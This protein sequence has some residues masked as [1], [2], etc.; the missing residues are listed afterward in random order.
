VSENFCIFFVF[1]VLSSRYFPKTSTEVAT[2]E[3]LGITV[4]SSRVRVSETG[5]EALKKIDKTAVPW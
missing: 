3:L 2:A 5:K 1:S 4:L